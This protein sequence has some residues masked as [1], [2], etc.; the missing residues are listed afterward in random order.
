LNQEGHPLATSPYWQYSEPIMFDFWGLASWSSMS[1]RRWPSVRI[2]VPWLAALMAWL[3]M[4]NVA[5]DGRTF[6]GG[7]LYWLLV[8]AIVVPLAVVLGSLVVGVWPT[9]R[10]LTAC[11][12]AALAGT[13]ASLALLHASREPPPFAVLGGFL[14]ALLATTAFVITGSTGETARR[15]AEDP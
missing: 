2:G 8:G 9:V 10:S 15:D 5:I 11:V 3:V 12:V 1:R 6:N 13:V 14:V 4:A 7:W